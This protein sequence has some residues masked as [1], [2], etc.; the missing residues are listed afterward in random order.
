MALAAL[1]LFHPRLH[2]QEIT[3]QRSLMRSHFVIT[4]QFSIESSG[5]TLDGRAA[6]APRSEKVDGGSRSTPSTSSS[7]GFAQV[8]RAVPLA[9][10]PSA[11][12]SGNA[13]DPVIHTVKPV[14]RN[15]SI[16]YKN[17]L[18]LS[19]QSGYLDQNVPFPFDFLMGGGYNSTPLNYT[20]VPMM[21]MLR[22]QM[23]NV[24]GPRILRGN[25]ESSFGGTFTVIP[26]GPETRFGG[27][28]MGVRRNFVP[29]NWRIAPYFDGHV[30]IGNIDAK[31]PK[32]AVWAQ[33]QD[34]TFTLMMGTGFRYNF[35]P[36]Y[37]L[38]A[39]VG[40]MHISNL[41]L[42]EPKYENYGINVYGP[43]FGL[44]IRLGKERQAPR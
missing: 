26:R 41:Y 19:V 43:S 42:S 36:R 31:G 15:D 39:G 5:F 7:T 8:Q 24:R 30:G 32:G 21:V 20:L 14:D 1:L 12:N 33:G 28:I 4:Q 44:D 2:A 38:A 25:W 22:W 40:Y 23:T 29:H 10:V 3:E 35:N 18:E 27:Y 11:G 6:G 9:G 17:R 37:S 34:L 13:P 16:Y